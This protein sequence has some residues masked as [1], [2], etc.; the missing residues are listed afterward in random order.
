MFGLCSIT[1]VMWLVILKPTRKDWALHLAWN[2]IFIK[3]LTS[4]R[5][6]QLDSCSVLLCQL[7]WAEKL[8]CLICSLCIL[9]RHECL[10]CCLTCAW[11]FFYSSFINLKMV[12]QSKNTLWYNMGSAGHRTCRIWKERSQCYSRNVIFDIQ[13][14]WVSKILFIRRIY[15]VVLFP[16]KVNFATAKCKCAE[17]LE[18]FNSTQTGDAVKH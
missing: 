13:P 14:E 17:S 5:V 11:S 1:N 6:S 10:E 16:F 3:S 9:L 18:Y 4:F 8:A 2:K 12:Q 7:T 15:R